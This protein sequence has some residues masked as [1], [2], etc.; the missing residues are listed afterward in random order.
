MNTHIVIGRVCIGVFLFVLASLFPGKVFAAKVYFEMSRNTVSVGDT[1]VVEVK[2]DTDKTSINTVEG[3]ILLDQQEGTIVVNDFSLAQSVFSVWP[4]TPSLAHDGRRVSFVGGIPGGFDTDHM[5]VFNIILEA[6][7]EGVVSLSPEAMGIYANDGKG[8]RVP[9]TVDPLT[10]TVLPKSSAV[11]PVND[12]GNIVAS[13]KINPEKL[14]ITIGRDATLFDG[15]RFAFFN[16][17]DTESG[18]SYYEVSE[19]GRSPV[20]SGSMYVLQTQDEHTV[21]N[22]TVTVYD[23]AGN[24]TTLVYTEPDARL[25]G[26][27]F[28][29]YQWGV[30]GIIAVVLIYWGIKKRNKKRFY[31]HHD[32]TIQ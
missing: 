25:L 15:K 31:N 24:K 6:Q 5:T 28:A 20:R 8:T 1:I 17:T 13:D 19:D 9:V 7:K 4:R 3:D 32:E 27:S 14:T 11:A 30:V 22:L 21:P 18:V 10:I 23:K 12:W 16:A 29:S 2:I 26:I